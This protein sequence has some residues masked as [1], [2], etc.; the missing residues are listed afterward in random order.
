MTPQRTAVVTG[1]GTERGIGRATARRLAENGW[2]IVVLDLD[3]PVD[4]DRFAGALVG[5]D[6]D[7]EDAVA[8]A[9]RARDDLT[10][11]QTPIDDLARLRSGH[12]P[13]LGVRPAGTPAPLH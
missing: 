8:A 9:V 4:M 6:R 7:R 2:A 3:Q 11:S 1:A 10:V 5:A 13:S 12:G